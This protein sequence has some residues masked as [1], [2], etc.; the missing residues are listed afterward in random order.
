MA[1]TVGTHALRAIDGKKIELWL[2]DLR[3]RGFAA[4][5]CNR[6]LALL[7]SVMA[8]AVR[9]G[10]IR[11]SP[12]AGVKRF[13]EAPTRE[14]FLSSAQAK[15]LLLRL[16]PM[17]S[18]AARAVSL[19]LLT[20]AR[21]SEIL[22]ARWQY[23]DMSRKLLILPDSKSGKCRYIPLSP[24]ALEIL[25]LIPR[26]DNCEWIF[27]NRKATGP[28]SDIF[29][30]W[31]GIRKEL[32]LENF[33]I[34]DLRHSYASFLVRSGHSLYEAQRALGHSSPSTTMRYAHLADECLIACAKTVQALISGKLGQLAFRRRKA[35]KT[36]RMREGI[37]RD[38]LSLIMTM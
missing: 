2:I 38:A 13:R 37:K 3:N 11:H 19:L 20:G 32:A 9:R 24:L 36:R 35:G 5:S 17:S 30:F 15:T 33:R 26:R 8:L 28:L 22:N 10:A 12:C 6:F 18:L 23:V 16:L 21:K 1:A 31:S 7:K 34:H 29:R 25:R 14:N 27:P 4:S